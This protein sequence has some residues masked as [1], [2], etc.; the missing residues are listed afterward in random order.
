MKVVHISLC[1][2]PYITSWGYQENYL[3]DAHHSKGHEV[4][5]I[6]SS[7]IPPLYQEYLIKDDTFDKAE[8]YD[9]KGT[10]IIRLRYKFKL[11]FCLNH[12]IRWYKGLYESLMR[13][14]PDVIFVHDL[15]F[16]SVFDVKKYVNKHPECILKA[17]THTSELN[18]ANNWVSKIFLHRLFYKWLIKSNYKVFQTIYYISGFEELFMKKY[19]N[20]STANANF[21]LL[22][23][24]GLILSENEAST[25][26]NKIRLQHNLKENDVLLLHSGKLEKSKR[27]YEIIQAFKDVQGENLHLY[28]IGSIPASQKEVIEKYIN[29]DERVKFLGWKSANELREYLYAADIYVQL[30]SPS[31]TLETA[32]CCGCPCILNFNENMPGGGYTKLVDKKTAYPVE[33]MDDL[34]IAIKKLSFNKK[35]RSEMKINSL[36]T[37]KEKF[38]YLKQVEKIIQDERKKD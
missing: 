32:M 15:Q 2:Y 10:K 21:Q 38:D 37:A 19:Y 33:T 26:R 31:S 14:K 9:K 24:G 28:I 5:E 18:S 13:E 11:P 16:M 34:V 35:L 22:P 20:V 12:R 29:G 4:V 30:G 7:Y 25:I 8:S 6:S 17:D 1:S 23:L 27:T 3:I 36:K